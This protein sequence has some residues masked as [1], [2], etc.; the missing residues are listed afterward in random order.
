MTAK[1]SN[2]KLFVILYNIVSDFIENLWNIEEDNIFSTFMSLFI[3]LIILCI[4]SMIAYLLK[5]NW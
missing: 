1:K 5:S 3:L 4:C 2:E